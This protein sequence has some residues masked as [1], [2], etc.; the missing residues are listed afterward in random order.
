QLAGLGVAPDG[1]LSGLRAGDDLECAAREL[2]ADHRALPRCGEDVAAEERDVSRQTGVHDPVA[3]LGLEVAVAQAEQVVRRLIE[4][5]S[6]DAMRALQP[7]PLA[8]PACPLAIA[9][10]A[11]QRRIRR[12]L[13]QRR[14][15]APIHERLVVLR[16][17]PL[18]ARRQVRAEGQP[19]AVALGLGVGGLDA[20]ADRAMQRAA[21]VL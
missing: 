5:W 6:H 13:L 15:P 2:G 17:A 20:D 10:G 12:R 14:A 19:T 18:T 3:W 7:R 1:V 8:A 9:R 4:R 11:G 16:R 21:G